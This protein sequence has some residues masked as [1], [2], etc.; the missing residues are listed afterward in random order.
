MEKRRFY[1]I[2]CNITKSKIAP[3][4]NAIASIGASAL[5]NPRAVGRSENPGG[6]GSSNV[7]I[8]L[9]LIETG[10]SSLS[11][12]GGRGSPL[13]PT[14]LFPI[15]KIGKNPGWR[16]DENSRM[17]NHLA[18]P[19]QKGNAVISSKKRILM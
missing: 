4:F 3:L 8:C 15:E 16:R 12:Y 11:K 2:L 18:Q 7:L 1:E 17:T 13:I 19:S 14:A 5:C 9:P 10:L 6:G